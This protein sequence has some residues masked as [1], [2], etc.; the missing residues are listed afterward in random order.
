MMTLVQS[1][2]INLT[3]GWSWD[4]NAPIEL[5]QGPK[6]YGGISRDHFVASMF[7]FSHPKDPVTVSI[8]TRPRERRGWKSGRAARNSS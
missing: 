2:L 3:G 1:G 7:D 6:L 4:Q 8:F 5:V